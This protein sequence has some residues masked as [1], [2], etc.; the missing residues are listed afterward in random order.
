[1]TRAIGASHREPE[2]APVQ[3]LGRYAVGQDFFFLPRVAPPRPRNSTPD[4]DS[5]RCTN[6]RSG[7]SRQRGP[8]CSCPLVLLLQ[9]GGELVA[10]VTADARALRQ[11]LSHASSPEDR[12]S[13]ADD[14]D[15]PQCRFT[16]AECKIRFAVRT[17]MRGRRDRRSRGSSGPRRRREG[18]GRVRAPTRGPRPRRGSR[19]RWRPRRSAVPR[20]PL[21]RE[22]GS[23]LF[24]GSSSSST[25]ALDT[26][27]VASARRVFSPP[28]STLAGLHDVVAGEQE[29]PEDPAEP[30]HRA[31]RRGR[32]EVLEHGTPGVERLVLLRVIAQLEPV[33]RLDHAGVGLLQGHE[34][35]QQGGLPAPLRPSTTTLLPRSMARSTSVKTSSEP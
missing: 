16:P 28:E 21:F 12:Q 10:H 13:T 2:P 9:I 11:L 17:V 7:R 33:A 32:T 34:Q 14:H 35:T 25:F 24:V 26:T 20:G 18:A 1:M 19:A 3:Q 5:N 23:R 31:G 4:S 30:R 27:R 29:G 6:L 8:G 15:P 22:A